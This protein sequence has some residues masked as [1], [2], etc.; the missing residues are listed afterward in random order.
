MITIA[1][2]IRA[3][4]LRSSDSPIADEA[5][6]E[7]FRLTEFS[8]VIWLMESVYSSAED[9]DRLLVDD[10]IVTS[11]KIVL[12]CGRDNIIQYSRII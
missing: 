12:K 11:W 8:N 2:A 10:L 1:A 3:S 4:N 9:D 5:K 7:A 6:L